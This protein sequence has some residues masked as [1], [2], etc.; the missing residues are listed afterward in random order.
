MITEFMITDGGN[1][2]KKAY[3]NYVWENILL[4]S[5][6]AFYIEMSPL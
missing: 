2:L 4:L 3:I 6:P 5:V 1:I